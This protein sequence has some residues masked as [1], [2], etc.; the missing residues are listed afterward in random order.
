MLANLS[1]KCKQEYKSEQIVLLTVFDTVRQTRFGWG[2]IPCTKKCTARAGGNIWDKPVKEIYKSKDRG[3]GQAGERDVTALAPHHISTVYSLHIPP[4]NRSLL[5]RVW[6]SPSAQPS[7]LFLPSQPP[8]SISA[9][10]WVLHVCKC[11]NEASLS[12]PLYPVSHVL[13]PHLLRCFTKHAW[14]GKVH[15]QPSNAL[16]SPWEDY[17][18]HISPEREVHAQPA[19]LSTS[20]TNTHPHAYTQNI[21]FN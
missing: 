13:A 6:S 1:E 8:V 21:P 15:S 12:W 16:M 14:L 9:I 20:H 5:L 11:V 17:Y 18:R 19:L 3:G 10:S 7:H 2:L 4:W